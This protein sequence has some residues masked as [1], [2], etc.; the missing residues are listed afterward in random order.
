[1]ALSDGKPIDEDTELDGLQP[2]NLEVALPLSDEDFSI[3]IVEDEASSVLAQQFEAPE[4]DVETSS[5]E[6][7]ELKTLTPNVQKR[8]QREIRIRRAAETAA[9]LAVSQ[10][11]TVD[12]QIKAALADNN[13]VKTANLELQRQYAEVLTLAFS[14]KIEVKQRDLRAAREAGEFDNEQTLQGEIDELRFKQSQVR[15]IHSKIPAAPENF[16]ASA[17]YTA[18]VA[19]APK[20]PNPVVQKWLRENNSWFGHDRFVSHRA[21]VLEE[22]K[23][24]AREGYD[25][26]SPEYYEELDRR[27]D[28]NFPTLRRKKGASTQVAGGSPVAGVSAGSASRVANSGN[29]IT[30]TRSDLDVMRTFG[31]DPANKAHLVEFAKHRRAAN[32]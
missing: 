27:I 3:E 14:D 20:P 26:A 1:M 25:Q 29:K 10:K 30:L 16:E 12:A 24:L 22:D 4:V 9:N 7:A 18:P 32:V 19:V 2:L 28:S 23:K 21:F 17:A 31:L 8:I 6:D 15:D 5:D 11:F 13:A